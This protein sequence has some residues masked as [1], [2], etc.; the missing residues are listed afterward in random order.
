MDRI[1]EFITNQILRNFDFAYMLIINIVTYI[2]IKITDDL[3][4]DKDV[5]TYIKR[6]L[7][8]VSIILTTVTYLCVGYDNKIVLVN[9]AILSPVFWSWICKPIAKKLGVDYKK[10]DQVLK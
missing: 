3:N 6:I 2:L 1:I 10:V 4:G 5:P 9:S 7:L 8:V